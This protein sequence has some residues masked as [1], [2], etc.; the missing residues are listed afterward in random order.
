M[1]LLGIDCSS[2]N[3][4]LGAMD[5][6]RTLININKKKRKAASQIIIWIEKF[7]SEKKLKLNDFDAFVVGAG[8]GS[9]TGLRISFSIVKAFSLAL[10]KP[11]ISLGSFYSLAYKVRKISS[12]IAVF[13]DAGRDLIY[14]AV[15]KIEGERI[16]KIKKESFFELEEF[17]NTFKEC[18]FVTYSKHLKKKVLSISPQ[19]SLYPQEIWPSALL[20]CQVAK[21]YFRKKIFTSL[22][23]LEPIY[24]YP[25]ECQIRHLFVAKEKK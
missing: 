11:V 9:F 17:V 13:S 15:F 14:G 4:S 25:K 7:L 1:R 16:R 12:K 18:L 24:V 6:E 22:K 3:I 19:V 2:L 8:P 5:D 23:N 20:L 21:E 10:K